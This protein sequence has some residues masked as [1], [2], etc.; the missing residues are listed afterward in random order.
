MPNIS[1]GDRW[2]Q[3]PERA[4]GPP[5]LSERLRPGKAGIATRGLPWRRKLEVTR[6]TMWAPD[7][8]NERMNECEGGARTPGRTFVG[9]SVA[10]P[11]LLRSSQRPGAS[12]RPVLR[13]PRQDHKGPV[14]RP[15]ASRC[16][17][18]V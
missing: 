12:L 8:V 2:E 4:T 11:R 13:E 9:K 5:I 7:I 1:L 10:K 17:S 3:T 14:A 18:P 15:C 6:D 16:R